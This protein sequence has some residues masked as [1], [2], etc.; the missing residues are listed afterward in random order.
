VAVAD[1]VRDYVRPLAQTMFPDIVG[2][3][4]ASEFFAFTV[5]YNASG[6]ARY[7]NGDV[8]L[9][10]HRDASVVT[11]NLN[12]NTPEEFASGGLD[13]SSLYFVDTDDPS[14]RHSVALAP[15]EALLHRG[16]LRH[17][18]LPLTGT[19]MR[20]NLIIWLFGEDGWVREMPYAEDEQLS[21]TQRWQPT[22]RGEHGHRQH[23]AL[24]DSKVGL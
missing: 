16:N 13:G 5:R 11:L 12:L 14:V 22:S 9:A 19:G 7:N 15:G 21:A 10:E 17:A 6:D 4:D 2:V 1:L 18:A 3:G 20:E 23:D 24:A 8:K